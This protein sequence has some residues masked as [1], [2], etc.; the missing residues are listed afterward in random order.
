MSDIIKSIKHTCL[1]C[2]H[3]FQRFGVPKCEWLTDSKTGDS[4]PEH[5]MNAHEKASYDGAVLWLDHHSSPSGRIDRVLS[6]PCPSFFPSHHELN[7]LWRN[8]QTIKAE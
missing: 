1:N 8:R 2:R 5:H 7:E 3:F 6:W 4:Q